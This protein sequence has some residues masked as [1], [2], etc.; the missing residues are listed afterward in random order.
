[1]AALQQL[2]S[3]LDHSPGAHASGKAKSPDGHTAYVRSFCRVPAWRPTWLLQV[4]SVLYF[5]HDTHNRL[6]SRVL[7]RRRAAIT[8]PQRLQLRL[9]TTTLSALL[10]SGWPPGGEIC[11]AQARALSHSRQQVWRPCDYVPAYAADCASLC[12][13]ASA[14]VFWRRHNRPGKYRSESRPRALVVAARRR[15]RRSLPE[16]RYSRVIHRLSF[17]LLTAHGRRRDP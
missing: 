14:N 15:P 13:L 6:P 12:S 17:R 1:M 2:P 8:H 7:R 3:A 9:H 4:Q 5:E 10:S 11:R 16:S